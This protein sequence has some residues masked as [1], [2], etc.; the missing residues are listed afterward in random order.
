[1]MVNAAA[2]RSKATG[3]VT[4]VDSRNRSIERKIILA[5]ACRALLGFPPLVINRTAKTVSIN[6]HCQMLTDR[7]EIMRNWEAA[8]NPELNVETMR[9][10]YGKP[11]NWLCLVDPEHRW[12]TSPRLR[13]ATLIGCPTCGSRERGKRHNMMDLAAI[14]ADVAE[15]SASPTHDT[16]DLFDD[17]PALDEPEE[18]DDFWRP[19]RA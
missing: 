10:S 15:A 17:L 14:A 13:S 1:M 19:A 16:G 7:P 8:A 3:L 5:D 18:R 12:A 4:T 9:A 2:A 6:M 11:V